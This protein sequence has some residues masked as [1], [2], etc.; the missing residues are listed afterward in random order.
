MKGEETGSVDLDKAVFGVVVKPA[1]VQAV[2]RA[3]RASGAGTFAHTKDRSEKSG[4]GRKPWRQK[5][6]GR[7]RHGSSRSPIWRGGGVTFGP[8]SKRNQ[9]KKINR[10]ER[11]AAIKMMLSDKAAENMVLVVDSLDGVEGKTKQLAD[12]LKALP[13]SGRSVLMA[14]GGK[15]EKLTR[16]AQNIQRVDTTMA[17]SVNVETLLG[18][19]YLIIDRA[20]IDALTEQYK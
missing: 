18:H 9:A 1:L 17:S 2:A 11:R 10:K 6:T 19:Q 12:L 16:A 7:A 3:M 4:G 8:R 14:T 5:G 13:S 15:N 20:G